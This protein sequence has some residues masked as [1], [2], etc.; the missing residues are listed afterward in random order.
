M[1]RKRA[2]KNSLVNS[3]FDFVD[4]NPR[5]AALVALE[6]GMLA[7][8]VVASH[9]GTIRSMTRRAKAVPQQIADALPTS[10]SAAALKYLP[11]P[12]PKLQ[13]RKRPAARA[14]RKSK[15]AAG[16]A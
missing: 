3:F 8:E 15:A 6:L 2:S 13:P 1:A 9:S 11:G 10:L 16:H 4:E 5:L 14:R 7:G 12:S